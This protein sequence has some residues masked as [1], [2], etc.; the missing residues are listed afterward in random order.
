M[1]TNSSDSETTDVSVDNSDNELLETSKLTGVVAKGKMN[2]AGK[3]S[4]NDRTRSA[5]NLNALILEKLKN[6]PK[7]KIVKVIK[8]KRWVDTEYEPIK[9]NGVYK[10]P[11]CFKQFSRNW[12]LL[13]HIR[14]HTGEKPFRCPEDT[15]ARRYSDRSNLRAHQR[16]RGHHDWKHVCHQCTK[17]FSKLL[18]LKRHSIE[19]C[20]KYLF[21]SLN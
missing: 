8:P 12:V 13:G 19:S 1:G 16:M 21:K 10:C 6:V 5:N 14:M 4:I 11:K 18:Y 3:V 9:E 2:S 7:K 15:C 17:P 20:R